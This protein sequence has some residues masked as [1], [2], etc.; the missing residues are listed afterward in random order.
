MDRDER[1]CPGCFEPFSYGGLLRHLRS[2]TN[3]ACV[4]VQNDRNTYIG[5]DSDPAE[6]DPDPLDPE[7]LPS[8][9][10]SPAPLA[11]QGDY[12]GGHNKYDLDF[13]DGVEDRLSTGT[14][15][16]DPSLGGSDD[17]DD[18][19]PDLDDV[20]ETDESEHG[21]S[22]DDDDDDDPG[23]EP[24]PPLQ[25]SPSPSNHS[26]PMEDIDEH[27]LPAPLPDFAAEDH[28]GKIPIVVCFPSASAGQVYERNKENIYGARDKLISKVSPFSPFFSRI[29]WSVAKWAKTHGLTSTA[30]SELLGIDGVCYIPFLLGSSIILTYA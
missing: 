22:D 8:R 20:S 30:V 19:M 23:W 3:Q 25:Q 9:S 6:S 29:D 17:D 1:H 4:A 15:D 16:R 12:F 27:P 28:L 21:G 26:D 10:P 24:D 18:E 7:A 14:A 11:F 13:P 2:T 5:V